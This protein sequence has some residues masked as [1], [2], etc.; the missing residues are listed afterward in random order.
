MNLHFNLTQSATRLTILSSIK[1]YLSAEDVQELNE[2]ANA[3]PEDTR[4]HNLHDVYEAIEA[5]GLSSRVQADA[6]QIYDILAGAEAAVHGCDVEET[7]FHEVGN[8]CAIQNTLVICRAIEML[9]PSHITAT[10]VQTGSGAIF[11]EHGEL[12]IPAPATAAI[13][14]RGIP[15]CE[16]GLGGELCTPTSAAIILH[17]VDEFCKKAP[18]A[19]VVLASASPRRRELLD[20]ANIDFEIMVSNCD[21]SAFKGLPPRKYAYEVARAKAYSVA[22]DLEEAGDKTRKQIIAADTVV[23]L[24]DRIFGK[25]KDADDAIRMLK[26]LSGQTHQVITGV[27]ALYREELIVGEELTFTETTNVTFNDVSD[28]EIEAYVATGAPLDKA[29]AYGAQGAGAFLIASMDGD[30]DN[31]IGLPITRLLKENPLPCVER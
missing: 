20:A 29:G 12:P 21:E 2:L 1:R 18:A 28:E 10:P 22:D 14:A 15:T 6:K 4:Y 7:H 13:I 25:P 23:A 31:V 17:F 8:A 3:Y 5:S 24:G 26:E 19:P 16:P 9:N 11:T 30:Y 27:C